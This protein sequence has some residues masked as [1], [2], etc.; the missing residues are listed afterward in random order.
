MLLIFGTVL[1][2]GLVGTDVVL[3]VEGVGFGMLSALFYALYMF[4]LGHTEPEM[5]PLTRSFVIMFCSLALLLCILSPAYVVVGTTFSGIWVYGVILG[6][7]GC[8]LSMFLFSI[9]TSP[10]ST[11]AATIL[12]SS[13]LPASIICS[14]IILVEAVFW[15]QWVGIALIFFGGCLSV[16][17]DGACVRQGSGDAVKII[18]D[19][20]FQKI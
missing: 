17:P 20:F 8:A 4:L 1:A 14:V 6:L 10:V 3:T 9:G 7:F 13:E 16:S 12:S 15:V 19:V 2:A 11:G 18:H 5:H